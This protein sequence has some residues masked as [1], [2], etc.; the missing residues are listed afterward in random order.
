[1]GLK[2]PKKIMLEHTI[3]HNRVDWAGTKS[4]FAP[5]FLQ[6]QHLIFSIVCL[7]GALG[8]LGNT[9]INKVLQN[10]ILRE[11]RLILLNL[12]TKIRAEVWLSH[13]QK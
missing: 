8:L 5:L 10:Q 1:M 9:A 11:L 12:K 3:L 13:I 6:T 2:Y 7:Q 4:L